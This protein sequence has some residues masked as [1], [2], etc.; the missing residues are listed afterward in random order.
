MNKLVFSKALGL[1]LAISC[2][3][4][5]RV[6]AGTYNNNLNADPTTDPNFSLR[7]TAVWRPTGS[8]DGSG[9]ISLT[10]ATA[11]Q[12]GTIV[13]P[14][15]DPGAPVIAFNLKM[16][17]RIG[18]GS[19]R[20]ADGLSI[21]FA[22]ISDSII[23]GGTTS[24]EGTA[25]GL[26]INIDTW[27]NGNGDGPALDIKLNGTIVAHKRFAGTGPQTSTPG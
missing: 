22:D 11:S 23:A 16:K 27:D 6:Q 26:S 17:V 14:N 7:P 15:L 21:S 13:L 8:Y 3:G 18:G 20:P 10:D 5:P 19:A 4:S 2:L 12:N 1:T 24:E 9:Y 25:T